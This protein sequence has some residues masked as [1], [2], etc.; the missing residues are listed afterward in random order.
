MQNHPECEHLRCG[1]ITGIKSV[2]LK[3]V[4]SLIINYCIKYRRRNVFLYNEEQ[5]FFSII[6]THVTW[7]LLCVFLVCK[8]YS[9]TLNISTILSTSIIRQSQG[10]LTPSLFNQYHPLVVHLLSHKHIST[11]LRFGHILA[12][13]NVQIVYF[14]VKKRGIFRIYKGCDVY[15]RDHDTHHLFDHL[16]LYFS[17]YDVSNVFSVMSSSHCG[18][19]RSYKVL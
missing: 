13:L 1:F 14:W 12:Q 5:L 10:V 8:L 7:F 9:T 4:V 2:Y 6:V 16:N 15:L 3:P 11:G 17:Y 18:S 19:I